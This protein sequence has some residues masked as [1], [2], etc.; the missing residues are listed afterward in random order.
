MIN[1]LNLKVTSWMRR[2]R[3]LYGTMDHWCLNFHDFSIPGRDR[4][5]RKDMN[6]DSPPQ[7]YCSHGQV[8]ENKWQQH[9]YAKQQLIGASFKR[10]NSFLAPWIL[11]LPYQISWAMRGETCWLHHPPLSGSVWLVR[12]IWCLKPVGIASETQHIPKTSN[13]KGNIPKVEAKL[14]IAGAASRT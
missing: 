10:Q 14:Y 12:A 9:M 6:F 3:G 11:S 1:L 13:C 2:C 7:P 5:C 8:V 4:P